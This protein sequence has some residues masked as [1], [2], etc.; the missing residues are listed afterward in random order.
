MTTINRMGKGRPPKDPRLRMDTDIRIPVTA[1]QKELISQAASGE[2]EGLAA[3]ARAVLLNAA[4]K[5]LGKVKKTES[6]GEEK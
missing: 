5:K 6:R 1:E 3:W 4:R 2:A